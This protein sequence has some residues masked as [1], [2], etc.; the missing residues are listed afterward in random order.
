MEREDFRDRLVGVIFTVIIF[1][2]FMMIGIQLN[3]QQY[4]YPQFQNPSLEGN[5]GINKLPWGWSKCTVGGPSSPDIQPG[6]WNVSLSP[7]DGVSYVGVICRL[8]NTWESFTTKLNDTIY[9]GDRGDAYAFLIDLSRSDKYFGYND[10]AATL[11]IWGGTSDCDKGVLLWE[12]N[13]VSSINQWRTDTVY[14]Q[15]NEDTI[16]HLTF[17]PG[18]KNGAQH[19]GNVLID[20]IR[21]FNG[22]F[23]GVE[24]SIDK[25]IKIFP[26]PSDGIFT[27]RG[28]DRIEIFDMMGRMVYHSTPTDREVVNISEQ[29]KGQYIIRLNGIRSNIINIK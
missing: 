18:Y 7:S 15:T 2:L 16:T 11:K 27:V 29:P 13:P 8:N 5:G 23:V 25:N 24:E 17:E 12:S 19:R 3:G 20:N 10:S 21:P 4:T 26:N 22:V 14:F 28:A 1:L 6:Y 9:G